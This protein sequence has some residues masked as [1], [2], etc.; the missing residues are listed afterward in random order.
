MHTTADLNDIEHMKTSK[1]KRTMS[2]TDTSGDEDQFIDDEVHEVNYYNDRKT[3]SITIKKDFFFFHLD[4]N[5]YSFS[6]SI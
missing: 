4:T 5:S 6:K 2:D 3:F 1:N